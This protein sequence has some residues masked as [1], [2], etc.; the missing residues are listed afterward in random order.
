MKRYIGVK[1]VQ[2]EPAIKDGKDGY[3]VVYEGGY[4]SWCPKEA[5]EQ[6]NRGTNGMP[7]SYALE[8]C[9][10]G[11]KIARKGWNGKGLWIR[12]LDSSYTGIVT[13]SILVIEYPEGHS[14]YLKG[15]CIPWFPSQ[16]DMLS[17]DWYIAE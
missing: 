9:K 1:I 11:K 8:A 17:D 5:F 14:A 6:A 7:F 16:T 2:A 4:E 13:H 10:T 3:K 12:L 15:S